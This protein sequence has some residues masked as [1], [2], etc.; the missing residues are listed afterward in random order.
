MD[1]EDTAEGETGKVKQVQAMQSASI[2]TGSFAYMHTSAIH[3]YSLF[4]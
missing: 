1:N 4:T 3:M 2:K